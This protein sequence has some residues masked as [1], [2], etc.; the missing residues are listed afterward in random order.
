MTVVKRTSSNGFLANSLQYF[1]DAAEEMGL[2]EGLIEILSRSERKLSMSIPVEMDDGTI[3]VFDGFRVQHSTALGP[4]KGGVRFHPNVCLDEC[5][6]LAM[7]MTWKCSL[8]GIPYGGGKGGVSVN[9]K[10]LTMTELERL[11]RGYAL[12]ISRFVGTDIDI[13]APDVYTNPQVM[14]WFVDT[15]EKIHGRSEPSVYTG[16]PVA[17]GGSLG[18]G[19]AT[20]RGGMYVLRETLR[21]LGL[22]GKPLT[23]AVQGYGNVGSYAH[24]LGDLVGL[25]FVAACDSRGGAYSAKGISYEEVSKLKRETGSIKG[26][27][28]TDGVTNEELLEL[29]VD[30]LVP[31]ALEGVINAENAKNIKAKVVLELANGP[32]TPEAAAILEDKGILVVP[33]VLANAGGVTVSCFEWIQGR[34]GDFWT[35]E[36]VHQKLDKK[37]TKA[38]Q[39]IWKIKKEKNITFRQAAYVRAVD[40]ITLAMRFRGIWP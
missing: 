14:S 29:E 6:A 10:E 9:A 40:R 30:V 35:E 24:K 39:E 22:L 11:S 18:R 3:R 16:K 38:F 25:N 31:A 5:E 26:M 12:G 2:E 36:E 7:M 8:A 27:K 34:T 1:Y 17:V 13:P 21:E 33:D 15:H 19:D 20:S 23:A 28:G 4:S 32:V 37:L